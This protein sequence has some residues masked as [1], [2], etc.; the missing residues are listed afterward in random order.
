[1]QRDLR[2]LRAEAQDLQD[3]FDK[4]RAARV[5]AEGQASTFEADIVRLTRRVSELERE[6]AESGPVRP[7]PI[8]P[9]PQPVDPQPEPPLAPRD[10]DDVMNALAD[11]PGYDTLTPAKQKKLVQLLRDGQCVSDALKS[12]YGRAPAAALRSLM[13][14]LRGAC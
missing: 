13:R 10:P 9:E 3:R 5:K 14:D 4:E 12:V 8:E 2:A 6:L 7:R 11:M 1:L